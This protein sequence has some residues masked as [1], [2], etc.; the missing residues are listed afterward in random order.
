MTKQF[1]SSTLFATGLFFSA[2][3][4]NSITG[5]KQLSLVS[6]A[7]VLTA[8]TSEYKQFLSANKVLTVSSGN[9]DAASVNRVGNRVVAAVKKYYASIGKSAEL[10]GYNWEINTVS[11]KEA[12]A[13]CMPG[14]KIVVYTGILPLTQ[15]DAGL[16]VVIGHEVTHAIAKHGNER[17]S[18]GLLQQVGGQAL[19]VA[20]ANKPQQTQAL[21]NSAYGLGTQYGIMLP[22]ARKDEYEADKFGLMFTA[23]A[24]YDPRES[25]KFWQRMSA[26]SGSGQKPPEFASTHPS[27]AN[28]IAQLQGI[29]DDTINKYYKP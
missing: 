1:L 20:L 4:T 9:N 27:D 16:A 12:N 26:A 17:M 15:N 14:G 21:Y 19:S 23:L 18:Q 29:M 22:F 25:V 2:C 24:G 10:E 28:R 11:N 3:T 8:A 6:D 13:W 5:R 7:E